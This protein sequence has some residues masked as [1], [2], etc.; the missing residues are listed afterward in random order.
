VRRVAGAGPWRLNV[1]GTSLFDVDGDGA[2]D[3]LQ[4][5]GASTSYRRNQRGVFGAPV[6]TTGLTGVT[7]ATAQ[8]MDIDGDARAELVTAVGDSWH[9]FTLHAD[10]WTSI[11]TIPGT[12]G[13]P[14]KNPAV[15]RL[16]DIDGD[17]LVDAV[18]WNNDGLLIRFGERGSFATPVATGRIAGAV[19]PV[20]AGHFHEVNGD[21]VAD[22]VVMQ[23]EYFLARYASK[24]VI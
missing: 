17:G 3:L 10:R 23:P 20:T 12:S 1:Q 8:L 13:L 24:C 21:G 2:M 5:N 16:T 22:Y 14:L 9:A 6:A 15:M 7:L 4:L 18:S 19:L 11:G